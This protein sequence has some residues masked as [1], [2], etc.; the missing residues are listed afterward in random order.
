MHKEVISR[1]E[2]IGLKKR[3]LEPKGNEGPATCRESIP[4]RA[5]EPTAGEWKLLSC[6]FVDRSYRRDGRKDARFA[7]DFGGSALRGLIRLHLIV[8]PSEF[9]AG[10]IH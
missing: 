4:R 8:S 5:G 1:K 6:R 9:H 7:R 3:I 10:E 2:I